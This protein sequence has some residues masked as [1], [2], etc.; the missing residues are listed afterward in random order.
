MPT[1]RVGGA[2][3][4]PE[5]YWLPYPRKCEP[6]AQEETMLRLKINTQRVIEEKT[7]CLLLASVNTHPY[8]DTYIHTHK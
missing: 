6:H 4:V 8:P 2:W 5:T 3:R 1:T 7:Q